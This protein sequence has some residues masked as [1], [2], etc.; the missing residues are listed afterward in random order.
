M[1]RALVRP[2]AYR[3]GYLLE[4]ELRIADPRDIGIIVEGPFRQLRYTH[5]FLDGYDLRRR[6]QP[7]GAHSQMPLSQSSSYLYEDEYL[8]VVRVYWASIHDFSWER[9]EDLEF[10]TPIE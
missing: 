3:G 7:D 5:D 9:V 10:L 4:E 8:E 6:Y 1:K 2:R